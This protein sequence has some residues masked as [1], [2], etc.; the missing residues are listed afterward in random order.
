MLKTNNINQCNFLVSNFKQ[1]NKAVVRFN[2][3][4]NVMK[5][6]TPDQ[7]AKKDH[8]IKDM[9]ETEL[10]NHNY[11][12]CLAKTRFYIRNLLITNENLVKN[13]NINSLILF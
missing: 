11:K 4:K 10:Q 7:T 5:K 6:N 9:A 12:I 13:N 1:R 2:Q 3:N 8:D